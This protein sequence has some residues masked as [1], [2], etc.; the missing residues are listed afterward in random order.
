MKIQR[1]IRNNERYRIKKQKSKEAKEAKELKEVK[2]A[3]E[4]KEN[5]TPP[6]QVSVLSSAVT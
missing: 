3:K 5:N 6:D 4:P 1:E 2:E